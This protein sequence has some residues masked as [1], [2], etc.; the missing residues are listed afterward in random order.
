MLLAGQFDECLKSDN[1]PFRKRRITPDNVRS[2]FDTHSDGQ[3]LSTG[4]RARNGHRQSLM[5]LLLIYRSRQ[6]SS[7]HFHCLSFSVIVFMIT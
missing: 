2:P 1:A 4:A 7:D 5:T 6:E 3:V